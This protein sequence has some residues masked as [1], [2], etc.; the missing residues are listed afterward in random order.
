MQ[1][2]T[3]TPDQIYFRLCDI[4][5]LQRSIGAREKSLGSQQAV[6]MVNEDG[7]IRGRAADGT[8]MSKPLNVGGKT[9]VASMREQKQ[10][11]ANSKRGRRRRGT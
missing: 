7:T 9:L 10:Q 8:P 11:E 6:A 1:V 4:Q 3:F 5:I 2:A